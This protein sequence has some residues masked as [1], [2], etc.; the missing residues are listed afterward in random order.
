[1]SKKENINII[2][3]SDGPETSEYRICI[4]GSSTWDTHFTRIERPEIRELLSALGWS[5]QQIEAAMG[6][7]EKQ[8]QLIVWNAMA[9]DHVVDQIGLR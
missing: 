1:M 7:L 4:S 9:P 8:G 5:Q 3:V 6:T 2:R